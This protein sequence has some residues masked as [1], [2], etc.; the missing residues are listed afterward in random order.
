MFHA[1]HSQVRGR[2]IILSLKIVVVVERHSQ[3][4]SL[5]SRQVVLSQEDS[6]RRN[7]QLEPKDM[8]V[9]ILDIKEAAMGTQTELVGNVQVGA[10][11]D[12]KLEYE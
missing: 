2:C 11:R 5:P 12:Y 4:V 3:R 6:E 9:L 8:R 10:L 7:R 1:W